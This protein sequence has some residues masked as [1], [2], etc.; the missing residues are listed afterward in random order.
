MKKKKYMMDQAK[1]DDMKKPNLSFALKG[2][3]IIIQLL[4]NL[5]TCCMSNEVGTK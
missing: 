5:D 3:K 1:E 4:S 2:K